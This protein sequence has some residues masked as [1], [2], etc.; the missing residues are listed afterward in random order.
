MNAVQRLAKNIGS[1]FVS[2][3]LSYLIAF[4]YSIYL[5]RYLG[6]ADFGLLSYALALTSILTVFCD[7]GLTTLMTREVAKDRSQTFSYLKTTISIKIALSIVVVLI[8]AII[9]NSLGYSLS[10]L[11]VIYLLLLSMIFTTFSGIYYSLF[12]AYQKLEYQSIAQVLNSVLMFAGVAILIYYNS[13]LV[14]V[15]SLYTLVN[16]VILLYYIYIA[17]S[18]F[19]FSLPSLQLDFKIWKKTIFLGLQFGLIGVFSTIYIWIDSVMLSILVNNDAVGLYNAAY[20]IIMVLLFVPFV[21]NAAIFPVMSKLYG[22]GQEALNRVFEK[23]LKFMIIISIPMGIGITILAR[24]I[25]TFLFGAAYTGSAIALQILIW[26]TVITFLYSSY[27]SLFIS[28]NKQMILT[29]I[30]IIGMFINITLNLILIPKYSY[31]A[32][33][34]NTVLTELSLILL[35]FII[36]RSQVHINK[37]QVLN[38][39]SRVIISGLIMAAFLVVFSYLNLFVLIIL[40]TLIYL[41]ALYITRGIDKDDIDI[42][43]QIKG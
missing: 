10:E 37:K 6:V 2:Q 24:D 15:A 3:V 25:I 43:K 13:G 1:L 36:A 23:Y 41:A 34:V 19:K 33:S 12:Q 22:T 9:I 38:D 20:R 31:I 8:T 35:V 5:I 16:G 27:L 40:G 21:M 18:R 26:S 28:T 11:Y 32:A 42:I 39:F 29:K 7:L 14:L 30:A 4:I 17:R